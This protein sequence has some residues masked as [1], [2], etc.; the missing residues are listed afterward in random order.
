LALGVFLFLYFQYGYPK[1]KA[2]M[3]MRKKQKEEEY[4]KAFETE[5]EYIFKQA[6]I[7]AMRNH[8][9]YQ[10]TLGFPQLPQ[11]V[12]EYYVTFLNED[13]EEKEYF[14]SQEF[15]YNVVKGEEGTLITV[16]GNFFDFGD[17]VDVVDDAEEEMQQE[18]Q[19]E[20]EEYIS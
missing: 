5:P 19:Q 9:Y 1:D 7:T 8:V 20:N 12:D 18:M 15:F 6:K 17:G 2:E 4:R 11:K 16:N 13:G 3:E 10:Q 14:V